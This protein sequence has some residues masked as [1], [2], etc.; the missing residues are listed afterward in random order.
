[1]SDLFS[2]SPEHAAAQ[3]AATVAFADAGSGP[4]RIRLYSGENGTGDL[5][6]DVILAKPC[7]TVAAFTLILH[8]LDA[9]GTMV[10]LS[11]IPRSGRW[12]SGAGLLVAAGTVTDLDH[13]GSF[14]ILGAGTAEGETSPNL[15]AGGLV[16]LGDLT[17]F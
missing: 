1:M 9:A 7:G 11:G 16:R 4:S 14:R 10:L 15:Y 5:L 13:D 2:I 17:F 6:A 3:L 12:V 8:P